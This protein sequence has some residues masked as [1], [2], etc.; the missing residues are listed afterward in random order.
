MVGIM[1]WE[2][3]KIPLKS[4]LISSSSSL[5]LFYFFILFFGY[6]LLCYLSP[7]TEDLSFSTASEQRWFC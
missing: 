6:E 4:F 5:I 1:S 7:V 3:N 2:G